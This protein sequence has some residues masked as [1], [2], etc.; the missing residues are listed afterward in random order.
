MDYGYWPSESLTHEM[1]GSFPSG[2][3]PSPMDL[4]TAG[5]PGSPSHLVENESVKWIL[6]SVESN[7]P[8]SHRDPS[9]HAWQV[10]V[11]VSRNDIDVL[12][13]LVVFSL[14]G[15]LHVGHLCEEFCAFLEVFFCSPQ[16]RQ[17][18]SHVHQ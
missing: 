7:N 4:A 6:I 16:Q 2:F 10:K 5:L 12:G 14:H 15:C 9:N 18:L 1:H 3:G 8:P 11:S 17:F 13:T